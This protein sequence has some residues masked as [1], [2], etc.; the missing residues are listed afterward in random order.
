MQTKLKQH[1]AIATGAVSAAA[2]P[3]GADAA[4]VYKDASNA[5]TVSFGG[6]SSVEW[7]IDGAGGIELNLRIR[8]FGGEPIASFNSDG[9]NAR[10]MVASNHYKLNNLASGFAVG[11]A[12]GGGYSWQGSGNRASIT[13]TSASGIDDSFGNGAFGSNFFGFR[14]LAG[15]DTLYGWAEIL[16]QQRSVTVNR[17]AYN[18]TPGGGIEVGQTS[19]PT[20][21]EPVPA[22]GTLALL[23]AGAFGLRRW[24]AQRAAA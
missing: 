18:G 6:T 14:F 8:L 19:D 5:F 9:R 13:I 24:R 12:L 1:L 21:P 7:D 4:I 11:P 10:G 23:A 15:I 3:M 22:P 16:V 2:I 17:W 20:P